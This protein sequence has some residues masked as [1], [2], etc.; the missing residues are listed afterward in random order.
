MSE[1]GK[2]LI[3]ATSHSLEQTGKIGGAFQVTQDPPFLGERVA[4]FEQFYNEYQA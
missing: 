3:A 2:R 1:E 4:L